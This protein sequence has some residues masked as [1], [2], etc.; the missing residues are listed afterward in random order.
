MQRIL[1]LL[2]QY[3]NGIEIWLLLQTYVNH[4]RLTVCC[5]AKG[6]KESI[7]KCTCVLCDHSVLYHYNSNLTFIVKVQQVQGVPLQSD[8]Q[9]RFLVFITFNLSL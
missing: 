9:L 5:K 3:P 2:V 4:L 8:K 6:T 1:A 7:L